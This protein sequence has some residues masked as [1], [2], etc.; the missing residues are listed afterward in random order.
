MAPRDLFV[1]SNYNI[2]KCIEKIKK[3]N[4][5]ARMNEIGLKLRV[6]DYKNYFRVFL[7]LKRVFLQNIKNQ[8]FIEKA[9]LQNNKSNI[10]ISNWR[11]KKSQTAFGTKTFEV[12]RKLICISNRRA[13]R[14]PAIFAFI[15]CDVTY[16]IMTSVARQPRRT[17]SKFELL[18][19]FIGKQ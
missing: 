3:S 1:S 8:S 14:K 17:C 5:R 10:K 11:I 6:F 19:K 18:W 16:A 13:A 7:T 2:H 15:V 9:L 12:E 4:K